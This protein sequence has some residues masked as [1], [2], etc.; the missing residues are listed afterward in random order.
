MNSKIIL[1]TSGLSGTENLF[2]C[3]RDIIGNT[4][5]MIVDANITGSSQ[6]SNAFPDPRSMQE[7]RDR[8]YYNVTK[9]ED[10]C[11]KYQIKH[12]TRSYFDN[13]FFEDLLK[14][15]RFAD[16][17]VCSSDLLFDSNELYKLNNHVLSIVEKLEC[18]LLVLPENSE[19]LMLTDLFIYDGSLDSLQAIKKFTY[20]FPERCC[21]ELLILDNSKHNDQLQAVMNWLSAHYHRVSLVKEPLTRNQYNIICSCFDSSTLSISHK[22]PVFISHS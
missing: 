12:A 21:N 8:A 3:I 14:E 4:Q 18:P 20:L 9:F 13:Y 6:L 15:S 17:I 7:A 10:I 2:N 22:V 1:A 19:N 11:I 5:S 16:L